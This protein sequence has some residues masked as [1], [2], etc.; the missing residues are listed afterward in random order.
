MASKEYMDMTFGYPSSTDSSS[1]ATP[2]DITK[3][4]VFLLP[5][6]LNGAAFNILTEELPFP[7]SVETYL[8]SNK[9]SMQDTEEMK[10]ITPVS[11]DGLKG[12][13]FNTV[14]SDGSL[15]TQMIFVKD[16]KGFVITYTLGTQDQMK[17]QNDI[18]SIINSLVLSKT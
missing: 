18:N 14:S 12:Y 2:T 8:E 3:P 16:S 11:L 6:S 7:I 1:N 15:V 13:R 5:E 9:M 4:I 10:D 17:D